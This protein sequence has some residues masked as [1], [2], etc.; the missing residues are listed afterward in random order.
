MSSTL[1][2]PP[3]CR[4]ASD[5]SVIVSA[6]EPTIPPL[7]ITSVIADQRFLDLH[8][9]VGK[10]KT[11][12]DLSPILQRRLGPEFMCVVKEV[13]LRT[14]GALNVAETLCERAECLQDLRQ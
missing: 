11:A 8:S 9:I 2:D 5:Y 13:L 10:L 3:H 6:E 14:A 4:V 12:Y 1:F 7:V